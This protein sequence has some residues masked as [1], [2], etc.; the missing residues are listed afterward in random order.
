MWTFFQWCWQACLVGFYFS[1]QRILNSEKGLILVKTPLIKIEICFLFYNLDFMFVDT[2]AGVLLTNCAGKNRIKL[3]QLNQVLASA[4]DYFHYINAMTR[5]S[6]L[7]NG[8]K[9]HKVT[10]RAWF[11]GHCRA[12]SAT[13]GYMSLHSWWPVVPYCRDRT[14]ATDGVEESHQWSKS[15]VARAWEKR[16]P[17]WWRRGADCTQ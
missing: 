15:A 12:Q 11:S 17:E 8:L 1:K 10:C 5:S 14:W 6:L 4:M 13:T 7:K 2:I 3:Q 16:G 9:S